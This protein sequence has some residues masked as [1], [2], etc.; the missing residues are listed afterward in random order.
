M[1]AQHSSGVIFLLFTTGD[2]AEVRGTED[3]FKTIGTRA[4]KVGVGSRP[5]QEGVT[6]LPAQHCI[7]IIFWHIFTQL[8]AHNTV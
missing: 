5:P 6:R 7:L 8:T 1:K 2:L 3:G 4:A